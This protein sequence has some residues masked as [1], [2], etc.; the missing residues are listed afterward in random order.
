MSNF[1]FS[2]KNL[3]KVWFFQ[4][5]FVKI[6]VLRLN[7]GFKVKILYFQGRNVS[8]VCFFSSQICLKFW[9]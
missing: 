8:K 5:K 6:L 1:G 9:F 4:V 3:S 2:G 7:S